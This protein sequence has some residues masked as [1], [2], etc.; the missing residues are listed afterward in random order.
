MTGSEIIPIAQE[1]IGKID[2]KIL[3]VANQE[4]YL[5]VLGNPG[6]GKTTFLRKVGLE[7]LKGKGNG[8]YQ[9]TCIPVLLELRKFRSGEIN[10][11]QAIAFLGIVDSRKEGKIS[12]GWTSLVI[13]TKC[14]KW[15][16]DN[17]LIPNGS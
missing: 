16:K 2:P 4:Q 5:M 14:E 7:T 17:G 13:L 9:H 11:V 1:L 3:E 6:T 15:F 12:W 8:E 10:L